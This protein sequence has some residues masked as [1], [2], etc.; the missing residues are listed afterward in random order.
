MLVQARIAVLLAVLA[1]SAG[2]LVIARGGADGTPRGEPG[3][4]LYRLDAARAERDGALELTAPLRAAS[5]TF[6][7][8]IAPADRQLLLDAVARSRPDAR[9]LIALVDGL[10]DVRLGRPAQETAIAT[11]GIAGPRYPVTIDLARVWARSGRRGV[12]RVMLHELAHVVDHALL[13]DALVEPLVADVPAGWT[14]DQA[15]TGACTSGEERFA[16][17]FAKWA[18]GDIGVNLRLGYEV[19]PPATPLEQW[20]APLARFGR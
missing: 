16:E 12:D 15:E 20:G 1:G 2:L 5:F 18:T 3:G 4:A 19:P 7:P 6:D 8:A 17:S 10:V 9:R 14:C 11:T 13:P